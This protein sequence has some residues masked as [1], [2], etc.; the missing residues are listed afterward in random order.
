MGPKKSNNQVKIN[1]M[2]CD[3]G[4]WEP[5]E[6]QPLVPCS[7]VETTQNGQVEKY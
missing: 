6:T 3:Y 7:N 1:G 4:Q 5:N 2:Q